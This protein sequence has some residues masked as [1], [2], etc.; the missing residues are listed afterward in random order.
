M[1]APWRSHNSLREPRKNVGV[2][3]PANHS[4]WHRCRQEWIPSLNR[5]E[6][7][8]RVQKDRKEGYIVLVISPD[9][10]R[11]HWPLNRIIQYTVYSTVYSLL[12]IT[13]NIYN[14]FHCPQIAEANRG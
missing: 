1:F 14:K 4:F 3:Q 12:N 11:G 2:W 6:K 5:R 9:S 13:L 7:R 10:P 8:K